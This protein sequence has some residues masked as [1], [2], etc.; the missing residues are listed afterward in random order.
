MTEII[1][2]TVY[3]GK[4]ID[5]LNIDAEGHDLEVL[6]SLDFKK[7]LPEVICIEIF[8]DQGNFK[9]FNL[10]MT[11]EYNFLINKGYQLHWSGFFS[12]IF[13]KT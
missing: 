11:P 4:K 1:D 5:F 7:Y 13:K 3:K 6:K 9:N 8:P 12:H 10:K 2:D